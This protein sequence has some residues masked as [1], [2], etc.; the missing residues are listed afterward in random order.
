VRLGAVVPAAGRSRRMGRDKILLPFAGSTMLATV[1]GKLAEAGVART[2]AILRPDLPDAHRIARAAGAEVVVNPDP[3]EEMLV[4]IRLGVERL[5]DSV[6]ALF[7][8]PADHPAV[9]ASTLESLA[10]AASRDRAV[11]PVFT[12]RRGHP[13][14]VGADLVFEIARLPANAGLRQLWRSRSDA[15]SEL[16]VDDPGVIE[17]L[18]DP[19]TYERARRRAAGSDPRRG[20]DPGDAGRKSE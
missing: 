2:V 4:S 9:R 16:A 3:D 19:E 11:I 7:V 1:L 15:V 12:G 8:W 20:S 17:N 6:D 14:I 5:E 10:R 13:A 18:D